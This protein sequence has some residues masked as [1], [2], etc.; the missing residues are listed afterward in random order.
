MNRYEVLFFG[1]KVQWLTKD[2]HT[3]RVDEMDS[4]HII[5]VVVMLFNHLVLAHGQEELLIEH[6]NRT[7]SSWLIFAETRP[8]EIVKLLAVFSCEIEDRG[9]DFLSD[10]A[11]RRYKKFKERL[12]GIKYFK[13]LKEADF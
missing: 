3:Y 5:N 12:T 7:E 4:D 13:E 6:N 10:Y 2:G 8:M 11:V 9:M 1:K